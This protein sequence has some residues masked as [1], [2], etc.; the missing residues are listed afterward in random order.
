MSFFLTFLY[1]FMSFFYQYILILYSITHHPFHIIFF[2]LFQYAVFSKLFPSNFYTFDKNRVYF[3]I[4][5]LISHFLKPLCMPIS[6]SQMWN[7]PFCIQISGIQRVLFLLFLYDFFHKNT[8]C[9]PYLVIAT[10]TNFI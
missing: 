7:C 10:I 3:L 9:I 2:Y 6:E 8:L 1:C 5:Q 4:K